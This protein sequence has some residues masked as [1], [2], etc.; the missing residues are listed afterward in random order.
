MFLEIMTYIIVAVLALTGV[1]YVGLLFRFF[2]ALKNLKLGDSDVTPMPKVSVMVVTRNQAAV[3]RETLDSIMSQDYSGFWEVWVADD[4]SEDSTPKILSEYGKRY[5][6]KFHVLTVRDL[7]KGENPKKNA[8]KPM[9]EECNGDILCFTEAGST[10]KPTWIS[11]MVREFKPGIELIAGQ[12]FIDS[13]KSKSS[14]LMAIQAVEKAILN[15]AGTA[16]VALRL[17]LTSTPGNLAYRKSFF[18]LVNSKKSAER[19]W[20]MSYCVSPDTFVTFRGENTLKDFWKA[21]MEWI[22][23]KI[24]YSPKALTTLV[25]GFIF[26]LAL[27]LGTILSPFSF[28]IFMATAT[29]FVLKCLGDFLLM[30]RGLKLF[31]QPHLVK[32]V[33]PAEILHA[34]FTVLVAVSG[35]IGRFRRK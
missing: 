21:H 33:V 20:A 5:P 28:E 14:P 29:A 24:H 23:K 4:R 3:L 12:S 26:L 2:H 19:P 17:P 27:C 9:V 22:S 8:L 30:I 15:V 1:F 32:W 11:G 18:G 35:V 13:E 6:D 31:N 25:L 34:P 7:P 16:A 10:V